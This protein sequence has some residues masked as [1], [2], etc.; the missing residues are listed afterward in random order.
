MKNNYTL[1]ILT[2]TIFVLFIF[3]SVSQAVGVEQN[4]FFYNK[5]KTKT[6]FN[7]LNL[8]DFYFTWSD[9]FENEQLIDSTMS[10]DYET[11]D[12]IVKMKNTY[13]I[14]TEP[15]WIK[16]KTITIQNN[17]G[18]ILDNYAVKF[19]INY[20][21]DMQSDYDDIRFKHEEYDTVW[22]DYWIENYDMNS[23]TIWVKFPSL[24]TGQ[25]KMYMFY[26]NPSAVGKSD[27]YSVFSNWNEE[28]FNDEKISTH[29]STEGAWDPD[30]AYGQER[31]LVVW[32][33]GEA[34]LLPYNLYYKQDIRGSIYDIDGNVIIEDFVIRSG[35]EPQWHHENPSVT[36]GG[37]TFFVA[38]EHY[39][40]S[41]DWST[42]RILGKIVSPVGNVGS[43]ILI[44]DEPNIQADPMVA[45]DPV[46]NRFCVVWEDARQGR[47][48]YNIY[49]KLYDTNGNQIG[50]EKIITDASNSQA[51][52][53][54]AFDNINSQYMVVWEEGVSGNQGPFDIYAGLFDS[55]LNCIG[56]GSGNVPI[57]LTNS[58]ADIDYNFPCVAFSEATERYLLTWNDGDISDGDWHGNVWGKILDSSGGTVVDTFLIRTGNYIRTDIVPYLSSSFLVAYNGG[59]NIWGKFISDDGYVYADDIQL[60]ASTS[61]VADWVNLAVADREIFVT[62]EDTRVVYAPPFNGMPDIFG[63]LWHLNIQSGSEVTI[64]IGDE[65]QMIL[66]AQVTSREI[67][68]D[69]ILNW[70]DF[71]AVFD[72]SISFNILDG[73]GSG[74]LLSDVNPGADLSILGSSSIRLQAHLTRINPSYSPT[75]DSWAVRYIGEDNDPPRTTLDHID[76]TKGLNDWYIDEGVT[77][78]LHATDYPEQTGSGIDKTFYQIDGGMINVY[79]SNSGIHLSATQDSYWMG[80]WLVNFWSIDKSENEEDKNKPENTIRIKIDADR[81]YVEIIEPANEQEVEVPFWVRVDAT[82]NAEVD[83]VEFDIEPF[84]ERNGL[85]YKD[86]TPPYEW[87]CDVDQDDSLKSLYGY[88]EALGVNLMIRAQVFDSS[89]QDWIHE[90][91]IHIT[92]WDSINR[93]ENSNSFIVAPGY[94]TTNSVGIITKNVE[95]TNDFLPLCFAFGDISWDFNSGF[96]LSAGSNGRYYLQGAHTGLASGFLGVASNNLVIGY[97]GTV[98]VER[99]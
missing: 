55:N 30:V 49:A 1:K 48:N 65:K 10:Y 16:M 66:E 12:G 17:A 34:P 79:N 36:Y 9:D 35:Q 70:Y 28:W 85:P 80:D 91:W 90:V 74:I 92:N 78:W 8:D 88:I 98:S 93:F 40:I 69:N 96:C 58:N 54:I 77:I 51:E 87:Y 21:S 15:N 5:T 61:A 56:P 71:D 86:D 29:T 81:P 72:G 27:Y 7:L 20:D 41:D 45:Y 18:E 4:E 97:A 53:W 82:D 73:D 6:Y 67:N 38:W 46:N 26:G 75:L 95:L 22:L 52:P 37:G 2:T 32:E 94:G 63:N 33:E 31:F 39:A 84:G 89:G 83:R 64:S 24:S 68:P 23:A 99:K 13:Q 3:V 19:T 11:E 25:S 57:K 76:G 44:C 50:S 47:N 14:W 59:D 60:S 42:L 62:W 43:Q